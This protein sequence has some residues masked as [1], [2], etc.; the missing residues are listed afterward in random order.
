MKSHECNGAPE[1][2]DYCTKVQVIDVAN[3]VAFIGPESQLT[4]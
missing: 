2:S 1:L 3:A 4:D